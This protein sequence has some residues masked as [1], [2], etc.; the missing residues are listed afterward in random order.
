V[1]RQLWDALGLIGFRPTHTT[2]ITPHFT[3]AMSDQKKRGTTSVHTVLCKDDADYNQQREDTLME[4]Y[5]A[6]IEPFSF[7]S[8]FVPLG[9]EAVAELVAAHTEFR[10]ASA[11]EWK[12]DLHTYPHLSAL[13]AAVEEARR[14]LRTEG[15]F[16]RLSTRSPKDAVL[17]SPQFAALCTSEYERLTVKEV[18]KPT[19][20][21]DVV[22]VVESAPMDAS[23]PLNRRL[24]A[25][26]RASTFAM[27]LRSAR[28]GMELLVRS[29][30]IQEDLTFVLSQS[31]MQYNVVVREF[32]D[33]MPELEFRAFI[34]DGR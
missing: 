20:D 32:A 30:R 4:R 3:H 5:W 28:E 17:S 15:F 10:S 14:S 34:Y 22:E 26:Y 18:G 12:L 25:L 7:R 13:C 33:F 1:G 8:E 21:K 24:H 27:R 16:I 31:E 6:V 2:T 11:S 29:A 19:E 23:S 9:K